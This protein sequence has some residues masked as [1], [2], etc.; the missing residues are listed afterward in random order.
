MPGE[1]VQ[2]QGTCGGT[3]GIFPG[4]MEECHWE[5]SPIISLHC[6]PNFNFL[7]DIEGGKHF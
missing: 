4:G 1:S 3:H 5:M 7:G 6:I 2:D